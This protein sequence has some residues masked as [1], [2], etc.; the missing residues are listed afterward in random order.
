MQL[1]VQSSSI[2]MFSLPLSSSETFAVIETD[3]VSV[4]VRAEHGGEILEFLIEE[5]ATVEVGAPLCK[6]N[7]AAAAP[8]GGAAAAAPAPLLL[9]RLLLLQHQ[10]LPHPRLLLPLPPLLQPLLKPP[11]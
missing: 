5:G 10:L 6:I 2:D 7:I 9:R 1:S 4:D 8:A 3:K 11:P